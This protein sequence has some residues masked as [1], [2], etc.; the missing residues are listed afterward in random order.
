M[1]RIYCTCIVQVADD[2][3]LT[4]RRR[5]PPQIDIV[6]RDKIMGEFRS[7][8]T[9]VLITTDVLATLT[10]TFLSCRTVYTQ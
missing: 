7:G 1:A 3:A 5:S 9:K 2:P 6:Y 8:V 4:T 10:L